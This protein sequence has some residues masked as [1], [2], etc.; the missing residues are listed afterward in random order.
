VNNEPKMTISE[1]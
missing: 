1:L